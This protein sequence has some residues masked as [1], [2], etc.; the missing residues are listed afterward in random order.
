M[1]KLK[2]LLNSVLHGDVLEQ[3][4]RLPSESID[5]VV[6][7]PPYWQLRDYG[8]KTQWGLESTYM[9]YLEKLWSMME[10]IKRI[11]KA[12]GTVWIN[13]GD[14]Y[15]GSGNGS[16]KS[17]IHIKDSLQPYPVGRFLPMKANV[18]IANQLP[19]KS[20]SLIPHRFAI[21]CID[22]GWIIRN[23]I[24]WAKPNCLPE[25]TKDRFSKKHEHLFFMTKQK[26]YYFDLDAVRDAYKESSKNRVK[27]KVTAYGDNSKGTKASYT[28]GKKIQHNTMELNPLGKNPGDVTDFWVIAN[29]GTKAN[30][31][32]AFNTDLITKPILAGCPKNGIVLDPFCGTGITGMEAIRLKRN[33]IGI[34]AKKEFYLLSTKNI[35]SLTTESPIENLI[36]KLNRSKF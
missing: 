29:K 28:K 17:S 33:F 12:E 30:H 7:S 21:G 25:S 19:K 35:K 16:G 27:Y 3:L 8:F 14:T 9:E 36:Q 11:L 18:D 15:F 26:E 34:E 2:A 20:L 13:L 6:T 10:E 22:R 1:Y 31:F 32:A 24:I 23:D 4:K 5:C